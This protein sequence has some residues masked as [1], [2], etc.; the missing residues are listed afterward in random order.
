MPARL[1]K[2][3]SQILL[4][5]CSSGVLAAGGTALFSSD[6]VL[7]IELRGPVQATIRDSRQR[8]DHE[9]VLSVAGQT[10][11][12]DVRVRGNSRVRVCRFPP[13]RLDFSDSQTA[14]TVF[15]GQGK[16][17]LVTHCKN[18]RNYEQNTLEEYAAY[19]IFGLMTDVGFR[20]RL[21]RIRYVDTDKV[22]AEPVVRYGFVIESEEA[23]AERVQG[24]NMR[25]PYVVKSRLE[26]GQAA[27]V[28]VFQYL[29]A[30]TD[31]S[32]VT[33]LNVDHCCHNGDLVNIGGAHYLVPYDFDL[34]GL[35]NARYAKPD[36]SLGIR[37]VRTRRYRGF[38]MGGMLV[39]D[40]IGR[41]VE[42]EAH[43]LDLVSNLPGSTDSEVAQRRR[44][45]G[46]FFTQ[47]RRGD[48]L[49]QK[50]ADRC[51]GR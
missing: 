9:F 24:E 21:L 27:A 43:I 42:N 25:A 6:E 47:A 45:L 29:I 41:I 13:L 35:V 44:Y 33:A 20:V 49:E 32:L 2:L 31:W 40:A 23:L 19:R 28:F 51:A 7:D 15:A 5:L 46:K 3:W 26:A 16:L 38:C 48:K 10:L 4:L 17:K 1:L 37:S 50:F 12:V 30:N 8:A 36:S 18:S 14:E 11:D 22:G 34:A 39:A